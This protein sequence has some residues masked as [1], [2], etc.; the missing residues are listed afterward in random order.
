MILPAFPRIPL[1]IP[2]KI[3]RDLRRLSWCSFSIDRYL[4]LTSV[5]MTRFSKS[6]LWIFGT[7]SSPSFWSRASFMSLC[8][9]ALET[10]TKAA[11]HKTQTRSKSIVNLLRGCR[12]QQREEK[13]SSKVAQRET[14][15]LWH[16]AGPYKPLA[17]PVSH[18]HIEEEEEGD[19]DR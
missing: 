6:L 8:V 19:G 9:K 3:G 1:R 10:V 14:V 7:S 17:L 4:F 12:V 11:A 13:Y 16:R 15:A 5:G 18:S 2:A